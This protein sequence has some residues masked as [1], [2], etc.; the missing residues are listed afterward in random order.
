M[1]EVS[2]LAA[3]RRRRR[4]TYW[5]ILVLAAGAGAA[6]AIVNQPW[7]P[8]PT[9]VAAEKQPAVTHVGQHS[10][11]ERSGQQPHADLRL[12]R[13]GEALE[14]ADR[15][16]LAPGAVGDLLVEVAPGLGLPL[17]LEVAEQLLPAHGPPAVSTSPREGA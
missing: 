6:W 4:V 7:V 17:P 9:P 2:T 14:E 1:S 11:Q 15:R 3:K 12:H 13:G 10:A 16:P 5:L 8:K